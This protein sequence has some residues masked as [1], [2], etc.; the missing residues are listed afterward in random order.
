LRNRYDLAA[1]RQDV[2]TLTRVRALARNWR[3]IGGMVIGAEVEQT[4]EGPW[5]GGPHLE[6]QL[7]IFDTQR[8]TL[9]RIDAELAQAKRREEALAIDVRAQ[10]RIARIEVE[11]S[12]E[13]VQRYAQVLVP[14]RERVVIYSQ[15]QYDAMLIGVYEL[16]V[17]KQNE[18][19]AYREL[20]EGLRDYWIA[21][22]ELDRAAGTRVDLALAAGGTTPAAAAA[23]SDEDAPQGDGRKRTRGKRRASSAASASA[24]APKSTTTTET[25]TP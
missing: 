21:R 23:P 10:I 2:V 6:I 19:S 15:Q 18:I 24:P 5:I 1:A 13:V 17:A 4:E 8:A 7:P 3:W 14:L 9:A 22:A 25:A 20:I 16:L 12:R 11:L